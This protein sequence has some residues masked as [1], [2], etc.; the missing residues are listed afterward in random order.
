MRILCAGVSHRE[1]PVEV[2]E[3]FSVA[4]GEA[5]EALRV[6]LAEGGAAEAVVLSTCNR[7]EVYAAT[8]LAAPPTAA[9]AGRTLLGALA[10]WRGTDP[11]AVAKATV[12]REGPEAVRH[13]F[14][15]A[16]GL[17]SMVVGETQI[18]GQFRDA[19]GVA[20]AAGATGPHLNALFQRALAVGKGIQAET[21][22]GAGRASV[23]G[24][25]VGLAEKVFG[26]LSGVSALLLG[27]GDTG[28]LTLRHL[29][30][31]GVGRLAV[32]SR[33]PERAAAAAAAAGASALPLDSLPEALAASDLVVGALATEAPVIGPDLVRSALRRRRNRPLVVLDLGVP[34]N[35]DPAVGA[36]EDV[37]LYDVDD[38]RAVVEETLRRRS[39]EIAAC[40]EKIS[41]EAAAF[42]RRH[43]EPRDAG[44]A[45]GELVRAV[46]GIGEEEA[47]ELLARLPGLEPA[48]QER[49]R[50]GVRRLVNR[51]L[52]RPL[53]EVRRASENGGAGDLVAAVRRLFG[54]PEEGP[55]PRP[56]PG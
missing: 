46:E 17:D 15:V 55:P 21:G 4:A 34:R 42:W 41:T 52:H 16:S 8:P 39:A 1:A 53:S 50:E 36:L 20:A 14:R 48:E 18:L 10:R 6:L 43:G 56:P 13:A 49:I 38:L 23:A 12:V 28:S 45:V 44:A 29:R 25:A 32:A 19:Y 37:F 11:G 9:E 5:P 54:L 27:A 2:R 7:V 47:R 3:R 22:L 33:T 31:A 40:E 26:D 24:V 30:E 35:V 51:I